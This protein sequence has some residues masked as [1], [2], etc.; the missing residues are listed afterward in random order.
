M[1]LPSV[2][3]RLIFIA[4]AGLPAATVLLRKPTLF[5]W[6]AAGA[7]A[8]L[9]Q[10]AAAVALAETLSWQSVHLVFIFCSIFALFWWRLGYQQKVEFRHALNPFALLTASFAAFL[11][12]VVG[13]LN[14]WQGKEF[15]ARS[16]LNGDTMTFF[17]LLTRTA[18]LDAAPVDSPF[19]AGHAL[20]YPV[21]WHLALVRLSNGSAEFWLHHAFAFMPW[22]ALL[23]V[24]LWAEYLREA[25][26]QRVKSW[27]EA[28]WI[29]FGA[30]AL[31]ESYL[32]PQSHSLIPAAL[33]LFLLLALRAVKAAGAAALGWL[34]L[35]GAGSVLLLRLNA[36]GG[37]VAVIVCGAVSCWNLLRL[38]GKV[39]RLL[40]LLIFIGATIVWVLNIPPAAGGLRPLPQLHLGAYTEAG[41]WFPALLL[42]LILAWHEREAFALLGWWL[43]ALAAA[44]FLLLFFATEAILADNASRL[45]IWALL[46]AAPLSLGR[47]EFVGWNWW[48]EWRFT[49]PGLGQRLV[50][51]GGALFAATI[52]FW[53]PLIAALHALV[54]LTVSPPHL[55]SEDELAA[56]AWLRAHTP[57]EAIIVRAPESVFERKHVAPLSLPAFTGRR[58][59]RSE[60]WLAPRDKEF[61]AL[62]D[63]FRG[64]GK[65]QNLSI[66][67]RTKF[68]FC[69][70]EIKKCP[71]AGEEIWRQGEVT[72]KRLP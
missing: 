45:I 46:A 47:L 11:A 26:G 31:A 56:F 44:A 39:V 24:L 64:E 53:A 70:P 29:I 58:Q 38:H 20:A 2:T 51:L 12:I 25:W 7:G 59:W 55:V 30:G 57:A 69:G 50:A 63:F 49:L 14:G 68:L 43:V 15:V 34:L 27:T 42:L 13:Y 48:R 52:F 36:V 9:L 3:A 8:G 65:V 1:H 71:A 4:A 32:Y 60:Y 19:A 66:P 28:A 23:T 35:T 10:W 33:L 72:I 67:A 16:F 62:R 6:L 18:T 37:L 5:G 17:A 54:P 22:I 41:L 40:T 21:G 61:T